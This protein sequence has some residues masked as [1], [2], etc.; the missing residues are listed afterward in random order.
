MKLLKVTENYDG[1][2]EVFEDV[3]E[4]KLEQISPQII[5]GKSGVTADRASISEY[6]SAFMEIPPKNA[7]FGRVLLEA[8]EQKEVRTNYPSTA[9]FV[10][11]KKNYLYYVLHQRDIP[12]PKTV[13]VGTEKAARNIEKELKG[14]LVARRLEEQEETERKK[15]D[16]VSGIQEFAAGSEYE[17]D[18]LIFHEYSN[19]DKYKCLVLGDSMISLQDTSEGWKFDDSSLQY[20]N[21]STDQKEIVMSAMKAVGTPYGEV[22]LRGNKVFDINPNPDLEMYSE[23]S[24]K[25][26]YRNVAEVLKDE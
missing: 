11:S 21:L 16:E 9:F 24:G 19:D 17:E 23:L 4:L 7:V 26:I 8:V 14:P 10:M 20:S 13:V 1:F 5:D 22:I 15:L 6:D 12:A 2:S 18:L 25:N 3:E